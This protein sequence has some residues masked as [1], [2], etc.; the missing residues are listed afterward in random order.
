MNDI[1]KHTAKLNTTIKEIIGIINEGSIGI[2]LI[3]DDQF[4]LLGTITDGDIRRSLLKGKGLD[5]LAEEVMNANPTYCYV[6]TPVEEM[7]AIASEKYIGQIP[8]VTSDLK[9]VSVETFKSLSEA[10]ATQSNMVVLM[11]GG[12]GSRLLPLTE[13]TPKPMLQLGDKPILELIINTFKKYGFKNFTLSVNHLSE[14]IKSHFGNGEK[15][16]INITYIH[17]N[18]RLGT[19][20]ALSLL[21]GKVDKPFFVMNA[22]LITNLNFSHLMEYHTSNNAYATMCVKEHSIVVPYG[23]IEVDGNKIISLKE[24]PSHSVFINAGIY[25][26]DPRALDLIPEDTFFDMPTLFSNLVAS[27]HPAIT[28]PIHEHWIDI[29]HAENYYKAQDLYKDIYE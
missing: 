21:K 27:S 28:F 11:A 17:E 15:F 24:K 13:N 22:D 25:V 1:K 29:G 3:V 7:L 12:L 19:A 16:G 20:G 8:V 9:L 26:L 10:K 18:K 14:V 5:A 4:K 6:D 2:A 23:V